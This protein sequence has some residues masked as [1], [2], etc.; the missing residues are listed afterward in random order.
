MWDAEPIAR[1]AMFVALGL[2]HGHKVLAWMQRSEADDIYAYILVQERVDDFASLLHTIDISAIMRHPRVF[3]VVGVPVEQLMQYFGHIIADGLLF[4]MLTNTFT[5]SDSLEFMGQRKYYDQISPAI[6]EAVQF[7]LKS[8]QCS[9][10]HAAEGV[11]NRASNSGYVC[12]LP[13]VLVFRD[14][15]VGRPAIVVSAGP[16]LDKNVHLLREVAGRAVIIAVN[17]ILGK[18]VR[19]GIKPDFVCSMDS[20]PKLVPY[21]EGL[22]SG[23]TRETVL[24]STPSID[25]Q[26]FRLFEGPQVLVYGKHEANVFVKEREAED[27]EELALCVP[28]GSSCAHMAYGIGRMMGCDPIVLIGQD[29][30]YSSDGNTH[31]TD[32]N[33]EE[34]HGITA[35]EFLTEAAYDPMWVPGN[36]VPTVMTND[37]WKND[38]V[39]FGHMFEMFGTR[40]INATEGGARIPY[41]EIATLREVIDGE[42][43]ESLF[44][45]AD[46]ADRL[47]TGK[48]PLDKREVE[49]ISDEVLVPA[50]STLREFR[51]GLSRMLYQLV[52]AQNGRASKVESVQQS[53]ALC[54]LLYQDEAVVLWTMHAFNT[55]IAMTLMQHHRIAGETVDLSEMYDQFLIL[56]MELYRSGLDEML[57]SQEAY[58][59]GIR[60]AA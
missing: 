13:S 7:I 4:T 25:P 57:K 16:S 49:A 43:P 2:D 42:V 26:I 12:K 29:L 54:N 47:A 32:I 53:L 11:Y 35:R 38:I 44:T 24:V 1:K 51:V 34:G 45:F 33:F 3:F 14:M 15:F 20:S 48:D 9:F 23:A 60:R 21:Y 17:T 18:L 46:V 30:S 19:L 37:M 27:A 36:V 6:R 39:F 8:K 5:L 22:P 58:G 55:L 59:S 50:V 41:T 40:V 28:I 10:L 52:L 56:H 31:S